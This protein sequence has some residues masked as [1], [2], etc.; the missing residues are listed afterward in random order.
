MPTH[1]V[2]QDALARAE[3]AA[4]NEV[5]EVYPSQ[6]SYE[7]WAAILSAVLSWLAIGFVGL[8]VV[9]GIFLFLVLLPI[10]EII[11][12]HA[13]FQYYNPDHD[14]INWLS[15]FSLMVIVLVV[16]FFRHLLASQIENKPRLSV[17]RT[18]KM[19][20]VGLGFDGVDYHE[21]SHTEK[22]YLG[23]ASVGLLANLCLI[24]FG[25]V[26]RLGSGANVV[27]AS[28]FAAVIF[29]YVSALDIMVLFIF[30]I[31]SNVAGSL[32]TATTREE[33]VNF[34]ETR[35][36]YYTERYLMEL[37]IAARQKMKAKQQTD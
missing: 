36:A 33:R 24:Y 37:L 32:L 1:R 15:A 27:V 8:V 16:P 3:E 18:I 20:L 30:R 6:Q 31:F 23:A 11:A 7:R 9:V 28:V 13:G 12:A 34:F 25:F 29:T 35:R 26:G 5:D 19:I 21:P 14:L 2:Y 10:T 22:L 17:L 4:T